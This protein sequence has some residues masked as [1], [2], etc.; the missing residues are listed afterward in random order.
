MN[1]SLWRVL[2]ARPLTLPRAQQC[3]PNS[4]NIK[5]VVALILNMCRRNSDKRD[6]MQE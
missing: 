3:E 4:H 6:K 1:N 5:T 2:L